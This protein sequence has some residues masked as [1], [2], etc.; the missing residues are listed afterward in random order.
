MFSQL[1]C[2]HYT[3]LPR[4]PTRRGP[5]PSVRTSPLAS[6]RGNR[7]DPGGLGSRRTRESKIVL[8]RFGKLP[9]NRAASSRGFDPIAPSE[10]L[11][12][13]STLLHRVSPT[14]CTDGPDFSL[15]LNTAD[16][17]RETICILQILTLSSISIFRRPICAVDKTAPLT[18]VCDKMT[19][20]N[21]SDI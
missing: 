16:S 4:R 6:T 21:L 5:S 1:L 14:Y 10:A 11:V 19:V 9:A 13:K 2:L 7:W 8:C 18:R 20:T 17:F 3:R 15:W 12:Y